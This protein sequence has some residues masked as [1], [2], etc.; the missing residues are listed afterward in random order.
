[1]IGKHGLDAFV[2]ACRQRLV[3]G[4]L[5]GIWKRIREFLNQLFDGILIHCS[6]DFAI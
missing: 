4:D 5:L 2:Y 1:M 3:R 6:I